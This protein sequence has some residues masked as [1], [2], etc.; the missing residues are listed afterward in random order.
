MAATAAMAAELRRMVDESTE[1]TY[2]DDLIDSIIEKFPLIDALGTDPR[3]IDYSTTPPT[4]SEKDEWIP[5]YDLNAAAAS[6]WE[7]KAA[8]IADEFSFKADGGSFSR[9][10]K[11]DQFMAIS[12]RFASKKSAKPIKVWIEPRTIKQEESNSD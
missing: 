7:E 1:D 4:I 8:A 12:R 5:T 11:Y 2:S 3:D 10:E 6:I 9:K